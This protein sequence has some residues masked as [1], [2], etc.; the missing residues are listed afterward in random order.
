MSTPLTPGLNVIGLTIRSH[1]DLGT[2]EPSL[3][4]SGPGLETIHLPSVQGRP[5]MLTTPLLCRF[6]AGVV[7]VTKRRVT[8]PIVVLHPAPCG[9][10]L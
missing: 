3:S 7:E 1:H 10:F 6:W 8:S 5:T 4:E 2:Q 9:A